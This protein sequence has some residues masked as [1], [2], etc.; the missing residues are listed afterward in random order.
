[1]TEEEVARFALQL[2]EAERIRRMMAQE[3]GDDALADGGLAA[4][5]AQKL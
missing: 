1:M 5:Q 3:K 2:T 4:G